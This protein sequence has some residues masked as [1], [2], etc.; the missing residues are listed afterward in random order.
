MTTKIFWIIAGILL[1]AL[2]LTAARRSEH[3]KLQSVSLIQLLSTPEKYHGKYVSVEGFY[4]REF[5]SS[6]LYICREHAVYSLLQSAIWVGGARKGGTNRIEDVNDAYIQVNGVFYHI[7]GGGGHS[8]MGTGELQEITLLTA[9]PVR[10][11]LPR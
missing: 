5:E 7:P 1:L 3:L 11:T 10:R 6:G 9:L 4:H 8:A 2:S